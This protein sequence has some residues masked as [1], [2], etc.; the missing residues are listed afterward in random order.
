MTLEKF[1]KQQKS[2]RPSIAIR[3][4]GTVSINSQ[5][6]IAFDLKEMRFAT[7]HYD[8][9]ESIMGI[10]PAADDSDPAVFRVVREKNGTFVIS[11]Q[12][13]LKHCEIPCKAGS[14]IYRAGWDET[15]EMILARIG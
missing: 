15:R 9:K 4:N 11:C 5:A 10:Q 8:R 7:L 13:F 14:K 2:N 6:V 1:H 3:R 12:A